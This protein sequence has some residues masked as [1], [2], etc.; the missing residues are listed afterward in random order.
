MNE[1]RLDQLRSA[2]RETP[3]FDG[4]L[5]DASAI[6]TLLRRQSR[7]I[8]RQFRVALLMDIVLKA[9][10]A[11]ALA[12]VLLLYRQ[13]AGLTVLHTM[14]LLVTVLAI[15]FE[16]A[17][18]SAIPG[19]AVAG[20]SVRGGLEAM[21]D[22]YRGRFVRA[23]YSIGLSGPLFF[24]AGVF[25][26]LWYRHGGLRPVDGT[27]LAVFIGGLAIA[28]ILNAGAP[29]AQFRLFV[30]EVQECL[31]EISENGDSPTIDPTARL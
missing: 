19:A 11:V 24:Y 10:I 23:L 7:D 25:C 20:G 21:L 30:S 3:A 13:N 14:V 6:D 22:Y 15:G 5:L 4:A 1:S 26:F 28:Y 8:R 31:R 16:R 17:V 27:D 2:W 12:G 9:V 18:L 29:R